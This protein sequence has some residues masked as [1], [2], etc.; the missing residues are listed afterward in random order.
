MEPGEKVFEDPKENEI[1]SGNNNNDDVETGKKGTK[2]NGYDKLLT[3]DN[4][5]ENTSESSAVRHTRR[6]SNR[7]FCNAWVASR[8]CGIWTLGL[9]MSILGF[10]LFAIPS[11]F[12]KILAYIVGVIA[13]PILWMVWFSEAI[14]RTS[15][16]R[17]QVMIVFFTCAGLLLLWLVIYGIWLGL[18]ALSG[19]SQALTDFQ[20]RNEAPC[21]TPLSNNSSDWQKEFCFCPI[22]GY[23]TISTSAFP[24]EILKYL[25]I[26]FFSYRSYVADPDAVMA[27]AIASGGGFALVE[28]IMYAN[29]L[30]ADVIVVRFLLPFPMH[31]VCQMIMGT[32]IAK[33]KFIY[34]ETGLKYD[35]NCSGKLPWYFILSV[36]IL[37]HTIHNFPLSAL[38]HSKDSFWASWVPNMILTVNLICSYCFLRYKY[39]ELD[40]VPRVNIR[41]LQ[42]LGWM[43]K[44]FCFRCYDVDSSD[45]RRERRLDSIYEM[46]NRAED[47]HAEPIIMKLTLPSG[48]VPGTQ[49]KYPLS[50][51]KEVMITV[52]EGQKGGDII[53]IQV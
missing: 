19:I 37:I 23:Y 42:L 30:G 29:S 7:P 22:T 5:G 21:C 13:P 4:D 40:D 48:V 41:K 1:L 39:L 47:E 6:G 50:N 24:E 20:I 2:K 12:T 27:L 53:E 16:D 15:V 36:G 33:R 31:V 46:S 52:Q 35:C 10:I 9:V 3:E 17:K 34:K 14:G 44:S 28:N 38:Q 32:Y 51:G 45:I 25:A 18:G 26:S 49:V 8:T 43:P 11:V